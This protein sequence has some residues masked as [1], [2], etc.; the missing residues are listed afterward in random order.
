M[1]HRSF[2]STL[3]P[4]A[5]GLAAIVAVSWPASAVAVGYARAGDTVQA[6]EWWLSS[7]H[8]KQAWPSAQGAGITVAVLGTGVSTRHPDLAGSVTTGPD[9]SGS[10]RKAGGPFWG[11]NGTEVAGIIAGHG[12]GTGHMDGVLGTAP[13]AKILSIRVTLEYN[14]PLNSDKALARKLPAAI[15]AGITYA[16]DHGARIIELPMDPGTG[17]LTG[18]G[19]PAAAGGSQAEQAAVA[20]ALSKDV[21]LVGPAGDDG[22]GA[23]RVDY[24]A[25]YPGVIA[26]GSVARD[27]QIAPFS[28]RHTFVTLTAPGVSLTATTPSGGYAPV[29]S[30]S[31]SSGIVAGVAALVL[32][33]FPHL[34]GAQVS[35]VLTQSV[36]QARTH[37]AGAGLGTMDAARAVSLAAGISGIAQPTATPTPSHKPERLSTTAAHQAS[38]SSVASSLIRYVVVGL[39]VL[40]ALLVVLLLLMRSRR[41]RA[42][43]AAA[44]AAGPARARTRGQHEQRKPEPPAGAVLAITGSGGTGRPRP[45]QLA[46]GIPGSPPASPGSPGPAATWT[47]TGGFTGGGLGEMQSPASEPSAPGA[48]FRPAMSPPPKPA[49]TAKG[50]RQ[51]GGAGP[52]WAPAPAPERTFGTLPVTANTALPPDPGPG[53]RV[54]R[55]MTDLPAVPPDAMLPAPFEFGTS[56]DPDFPPRPRARQGD[57][58][59]D[60]PP[61]RVQLPARQSLGFAAAPVPV[62]YAPPQAPDFTVPSRAAGLVLSAGTAGAAGTDTVPAAPAESRA[63]GSK[64]A[65]PSFIWNLSGTDVFPTAERPDEP[66]APEAPGAVPADDD[67]GTSAG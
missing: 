33:R 60:V 49:K 25:A 29:S 7:L 12:H 22:Q 47:A 56:P 38:A 26:V 67:P 27:G 6:S 50:T 52:P 44:A 58:F 21:I 31:M 11:V 16:V 51:A 32:S 15:A 35:Q 59:P 64:A 3:I 40:I 46:P 66:G 45:P 37:A 23:G 34:T 53:I 48:P 28:S 62:D 65:D 9:F 5:A 55:D 17:G 18:Q 54:P 42:R 39:G 19:N 1:S 36:T 8:V 43:A 20:N 30:T 4:V 14:D 10:G 41:E 61:S 2:R 13:A 24:P 63:P 57:D